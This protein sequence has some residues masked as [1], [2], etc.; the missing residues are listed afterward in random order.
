M[1]HQLSPSNALG[2]AG[3]GCTGGTQRTTTAWSI[4]LLFKRI[5]SPVTLERA[6]PPLCHQPHGTSSC[7]AHPA[8]QP[9]PTALPGTAQSPALPCLYLV[10]FFTCF[11]YE[12]SPP[13]AN[14]ELPPPLVWEA[15]LAFLFLL[16]FSLPLARPQ[17]QPHDGLEGRSP[18]ALFGHGSR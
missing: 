4:P 3:A 9:S 5:I 18:M 2:V 12:D 7:C 16:F 15:L 6:W 8:T 13:S 17:A 10:N 14:T 1:H 11:I